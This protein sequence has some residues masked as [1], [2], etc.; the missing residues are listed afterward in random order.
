MA[1]DSLTLTQALVACPSV[2]PNDAG[3][4]III[5]NMLRDAGFTIEWIHQNGVSNLWARFGT[6][7][8]LYCFAG[9]TDVVPVGPL[10]DWQHPPFEATCVDGKLYGRGV[11]DMKGGLAAMVVAAIAW[12][13]YPPAQGSL[14][15]LITSDEEGPAQDGTRHVLNVLTARGE[16]FA[17]V[18]I[19]EPTGSL[20]TGDV[21]K[22]G[23]RG[24]LHGSFHFRALADHVAYAAL[25]NNVMVQGMRALLAVVQHPWDEDMECFP[26]TSCQMV[27]LHSDAGAKNLIPGEMTAHINWRFSPQL[28]TAQIMAQTTA[29]VALHAPNCVITWQVSGHPFFTPANHFLV[30]AVQTA[31]TNVT[32]IPATLSTAGG[33]SDGRFFA[34]LGI[35]VV[36]CG[37]V[38]ATIHQ[39]NEH[40]VIE[41]L[42]RLTAI[43]SKLLQVLF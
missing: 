41:D 39:V 32:G 23:R 19:G 25:E 4:Q 20:Q 8:P 24:S 2:T 43:Y 15:L 31:I 40:I 30:Q 9:H 36:E 21:I 42:A 18:I 22:N 5:A 1:L 27:A 26:A 13:A 14:A 6:T 16:S 11:A 12:A 35:P 38:N 3:C 7:V 17:G 10:T 28:T 33:T 37:L 29:L 34:A